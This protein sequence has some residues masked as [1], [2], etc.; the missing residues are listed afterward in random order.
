MV[1]RSTCCSGES[2]AQARECW[3][4]AGT[5]KPIIK[6][7]NTKKNKNKN[8]AGKEDESN[9]GVSGPRRVGRT[10]ES[11]ESKGDAKCQM[12]DGHAKRATEPTGHGFEVWGRSGRGVVIN[13]RRRSKRGRAGRPKQASC[14]AE[15][16]ARLQE[17]SNRQRS[18]G[19]GQ[20]EHEPRRCRFARGRPMQPDGASARREMSRATTARRARRALRCAP[21]TLASTRWPWA[22]PRLWRRK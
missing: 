4:G 21:G 18:P 22:Q 3:R 16:G 5:L 11:R 9:D 10:V 12:L 6:E 14:A 2:W 8:N 1:Q 17:R 7:E 19:S 20:V 13:G 15:A